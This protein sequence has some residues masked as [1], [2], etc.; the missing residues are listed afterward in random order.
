MTQTESTTQM[1]LATI[2]KNLRNTKG[3]ID[4]SVISKK[5]KRIRS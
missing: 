3:D 1:N 2:S 4:F 5:T